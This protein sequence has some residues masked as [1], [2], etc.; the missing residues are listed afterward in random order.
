MFLAGSRQQQPH[1][2]PHAAAG[3][4]ARCTLA[5]CLQLVKKQQSNQQH[6]I[7]DGPAASHMPLRRTPW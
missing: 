7:N 3:P 2:E 4:L 5:A 6:M 1:A